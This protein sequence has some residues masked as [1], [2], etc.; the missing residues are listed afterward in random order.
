MCRV[1]WV[2]GCTRW[3][4]WARPPYSSAPASTTHNK[5][6]TQTDRGRG[7][8]LA[9]DRHRRKNE[10]EGKL[11]YIQRKWNSATQSPFTPS[12]PFPLCLPGSSHRGLCVLRGSLRSM[13]WGRWGRPAPPSPL[14]TP[15]QRS[16]L[17]TGHKEE[18]ER[19]GF[20][21]EKRRDGIYTYNVDID[22]DI[23]I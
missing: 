7:G 20:R 4:V 3:W 21:E 22:I 1:P 5:H 9:N 2:V 11:P 18:R 19:G 12:S 16:R 13:P 23:S 14:P 8:K 15:P 6:I 17:H 10:G